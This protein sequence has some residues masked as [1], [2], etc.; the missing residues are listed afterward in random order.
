MKG[1]LSR[2]RRSERPQSRGT[3]LLDPGLSEGL[4]LQ[5][6]GSTAWQQVQWPLLANGCYSYELFFVPFF[7]HSLY[8]G[9]CEVLL[10]FVIVFCFFSF[11]YSV[12]VYYEERDV[13]SPRGPP[14]TH[15]PSVTG[16]TYASQPDYSAHCAI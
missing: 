1:G 15:P 7:I 5:V 12:R 8:A 2:G 14:S 10:F 3:I 4:R 6:S 13:P 9:M 11:L 16:R